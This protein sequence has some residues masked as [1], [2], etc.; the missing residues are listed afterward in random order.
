MYSGTRQM[1]TSLSSALASCFLNWCHDA[2]TATGLRPANMVPSTGTGPC[3]TC[4]RL[5]R[6]VP[7]SQYTTRRLAQRWVMNTRCTRSVLA[8]HI[9]LSAPLAL[10]LCDMTYC[11]NTFRAALRTLYD[12]PSYIL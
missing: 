3:Q 1:Y 8:R 6:T 10:L 4:M 7:T 12:S 2:P 11:G 9:A 5:W